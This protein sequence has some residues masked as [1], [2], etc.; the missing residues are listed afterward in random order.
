MPAPTRRRTPP[1]QRL[2]QTPT[3][4]EHAL[5]Q[6]DGLLEIVLEYQ[7]GRSDAVNQQPQC[8]VCHPAPQHLEH[9]IGALGVAH[10]PSQVGDPCQTPT[11]KMEFVHR[12]G[13]KSAQR[14][15]GFGG[16]ALP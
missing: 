2:P 5:G 3:V 15:L 16:I 1:I 14:L 9:L 6:R 10:R 13:F 4:G 11:D 12:V 7:R 8:G